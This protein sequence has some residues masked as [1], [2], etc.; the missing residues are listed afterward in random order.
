[1][2]AGDSFKYYFKVNSSIDEDA[3]ESV[4]VSMKDM[5]GKASGVTQ[6]VSAA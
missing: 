5:L 4:V 2:K 6:R 3:R 1:M